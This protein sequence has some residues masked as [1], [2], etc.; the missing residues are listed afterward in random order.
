MTQI[1]STKIHI[2]SKRLTFP[3]ETTKEGI[4]MCDNIYKNC[5]Y[6]AGKL[7]PTEMRVMQPRKRVADYAVR[8]C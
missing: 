4:K 1:M 3:T 6:F 7:T 2:I 5:P 8:G